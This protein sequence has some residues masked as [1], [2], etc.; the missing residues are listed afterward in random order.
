MNIL[1]GFFWNASS[2]FHPQPLC[3]FSLGI[4][5]GVQALTDVSNVKCRSLSEKFPDRVVHEPENLKGRTALICWGHLRSRR[6]IG[7]C[8]LVALERDTHGEDFAG[9]LETR[10]RTISK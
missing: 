2:W 1:G 4:S 5:F 8:G 7:G 3:W 10:D 9:V 6:R